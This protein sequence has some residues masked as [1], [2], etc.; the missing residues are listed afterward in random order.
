MHDYFNVQAFNNTLAT[1]V[2]LATTRIVNSLL[3]AV[4]RKD[5]HHLPK[6]LLVIIDK[7]LM[8]D[9]EIHTSNVVA[10][11]RDLVQ[12]LMR[13]LDMVIRRKR[14]ELLEHKLGAA[15]GYTTKLIFVRMPRRVGSFFLN[16]RV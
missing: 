14:M 8:T 15:S 5:L 10:T 12:W 13:Q 16:P 9:L 6:I 11:M 7:D 4:N 1:G 3:E 2:K